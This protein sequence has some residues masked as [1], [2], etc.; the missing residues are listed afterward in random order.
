MYEI[1]AYLKQL[2]DHYLLFD[3][4]NW[5][6]NKQDNSGCQYRNIRYNKNT[7]TFIYEMKTPNERWSGPYHGRTISDFLKM[8]EI[9]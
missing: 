5:V 6:L 9:V 7:K 2:H 1:Q 4:S 3:I 8:K